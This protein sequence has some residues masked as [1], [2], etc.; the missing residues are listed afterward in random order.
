MDGRQLFTL[1]KNEQP[2]TIAF[3]LSCLELKKGAELVSLLDSEV[4]EEVLERFGS[5]DGASQEAMAKV[6]KS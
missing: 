6:A 5:M 2:Q 1:I 4:R 3:I